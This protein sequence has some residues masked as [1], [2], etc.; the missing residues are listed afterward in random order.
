MGGTVT[1][2]ATCPEDA[3]HAVVLAG[4]EEA[5]EAFFTRRATPAPVGRSRCACRS[6]RATRLHQAG[7]AIGMVVCGSETEVPPLADSG[8]RA[9]PRSC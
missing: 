5:D 4:N 3:T 8:V 7:Q 1:V 9:S 2:S 6:P